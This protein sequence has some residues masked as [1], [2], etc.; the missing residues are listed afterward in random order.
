MR[1]KLVGGNLHECDILQ[2]R[3]RQKIIQKIDR[4]FIAVRLQPTEISRWVGGRNREQWLAN[5]V[6]GVVIVSQIRKEFSRNQQARAATEWFLANFVALFLFGP[7]ERTQNG[8]SN[9]VQV[10]I[11]FMNYFEQITFWE[12]YALTPTG[13]PP[14]PNLANIREGSVQLQRRSEET[15]ALLQNYVENTPSAGFLL[16]PEKNRAAEAETV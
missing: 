4:V 16:K 13:D 5:V 7:I 9:L 1:E 10:E 15:M 11:A 12:T 3:P 2:R 14:A 6:H 8:L